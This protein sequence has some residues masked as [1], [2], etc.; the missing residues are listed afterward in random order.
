MKNV[1]EIDVIWYTKN[2]IAYEFEVEN[3]TGGQ[4]AIIRGSNIPNEKVKRLIVIPE[5]RQETIYN[6]INV[7]AL[8]ERVQT[9]NWRFIFYDELKNFFDSV[10]RKQK[11]NLE[12]FEKIFKTPQEPK[13]KVETSL[14]SFSSRT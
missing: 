5:E 14:D 2:D 13:K 8:K 10:K 1:K 12:D 9:E 3:T 4:S 7:P 11:I 6:K